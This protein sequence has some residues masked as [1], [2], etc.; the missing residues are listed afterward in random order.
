MKTTVVIPTLNEESTIKKVISDFK[1]E[2]KDCTIVVYDGNST[3]KTCD[4]AK[5]M[6]ARVMLQEGKGKGSAIREIFDKIDSDIYV[7]VDGD[8]TYPADVCKQLIKTLKDENADLVIGTRLK[9][10]EKGSLKGLHI[11][12]NKIITGL[13]NLFFNKKLN[14]ILSGYRIFN[15]KLAKG[16]KLTSEGFEVETEMTIKSLISNYKIIEI[17]VKYRSRPGE[18]KSKLSSF[19]DGSLIIYTIIILFRDYRPLF[20]FSIIS[21]IT[22]ILGLGLGGFV[23]ENWLNT[24]IVDRIPTTVLSSLLIFLSIQFFSIG[25]ILDS[26]NRKKM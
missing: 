16:L 2:L 21:T 26:I 11:F 8:D 18:S 19:G 22:L 6:G 14:D 24:G 13:V 25:I 1:K 17:P 9:L 23:F 7:M 10:R 12:G 20:F 5:K 15:R 3:D 4:I